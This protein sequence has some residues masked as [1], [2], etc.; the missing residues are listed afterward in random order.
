M[1]RSQLRKDLGVSLYLLANFYSIVHTT[2]ALRITGREGDPTLKHSPGR[3]LGKARGQVYVKELAL[4]GGLRQH[5]AFTVWEPN[6]GG[7]F[8][9][10]QY[11]AIIQQVQK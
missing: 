4:L 6:F 2:V 5:S 1:A 3:R 7:K 11:D 10:E 9:K 8:P